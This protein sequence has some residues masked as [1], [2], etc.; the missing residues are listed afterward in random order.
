METWEIDFAARPW[1]DAQGKKVWELLV[2]S[3]SGNYR[4]FAQ[5]SQK[6][7]T[8]AWILDNLGKA[9]VESGQ[10][11]GQIRF[12]SPSGMLEQACI[13]LEIPSRMSRRVFWVRRWLYDREQNVYPTY[14]GYCP[15]PLSSIPPQPLPDPLVAQRWAFVSLCAAD[16]MGI[17]TDRLFGEVFP[18]DLAPETVVPGLVFFSPRA[19]AMAAWMQGVEPVAVQFCDKE[20]LILEAGAG[21]R[22]VVV[23]PRDRAIQQEASLFEERKIP[24][25]GFHF[26]AIQ[27]GVDSEEPTGFWTLWDTPPS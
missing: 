10:K 12:L 18:L 4:Y 11:P 14:E 22:W 26:L 24:S 1:V 5:C 19:T 23:R 3:R 21:E 16:L 17:S 15:Q 7:V 20:R 2:C 13:Q 8:R 6:E 27:A 25:Q 9:M